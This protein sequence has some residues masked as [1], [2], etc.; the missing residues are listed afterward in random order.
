MLISRLKTKLTTQVQPGRANHFTASKSGFLSCVFILL[1]SSSPPAISEPSQVWKELE[2]WSIR[3]HLEDKSRCYAS[4]RL[5]NG[6][7]VQIGTEPTLDGGYFAI[8]NVAWKHLEEG[9][10]GSVVFDFGTSRFGGETIVR[11]EN[12]VPGGYAFFNNPEFVQTFA[13]RYEVTIKGSSGASFTLDLKGTSRAIRAVL[14]CQDAQPD[15]Q[16]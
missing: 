1:C 15:A 6:S 4:R 14:A 9:M 8:Y 12:G 16:D 11:F 13:R 5:D 10:T 2:L 7:E 3:I